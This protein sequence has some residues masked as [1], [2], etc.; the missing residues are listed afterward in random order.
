MNTPVITLVGDHHV[1][2][3]TYSILKYLTIT[4]TIARSP[5]EYVEKAVYLIEHPDAL[6]A[7][8]ARL[9]KILQYETETHPRVYVENLETAYQIMWRCFKEGSPLKPISI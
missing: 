7:I 5:A 3:T 6:R 8:K 4:D 2:R 9:F 1:Q